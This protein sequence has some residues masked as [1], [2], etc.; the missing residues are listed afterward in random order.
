M[1]TSEIIKDTGD[2]G[3]GYIIRDGFVF[4]AITHPANIFDGVVI[5][6]PM[7]ATYWASRDYKINK[8]ISEQIEFVNLNRIEKAFIIAKDISFIKQCPT[9]KYLIICPADNAGD[10]FDFTPLYDLPEI[11]SLKCVT[12]Y[13][14]KQ[15][16]T[17][18]ID[19][20]K[21][22]G[23]E[24]L[25]IEGSGHLNYNHLVNLKSL[26]VS[27][28]KDIDLNNMISSE[29]LDTIKLNQCKVQSLRGIEK[30]CKLQCLYLE[31]NR[32]L[33]DISALRNVKNT[34]KLLRIENC[35]KIKDFS[36]LS[37]L[38]Q[39]ELLQVIGTTE[40][41][42][43]EFLKSL[44]NLKTFVCDMNVLDGNLTPCLDIPYVYISKYRKHYNLDP[45]NFTL[46][47]ISRGNEDIEVWRRME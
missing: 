24:S 7:N 34:I 35:A 11:K 2:L 41:E 4:R 5:M 40:I 20:S 38:H 32:A 26:S 28:S 30:S 8:S 29:I 31:Y 16:Y 18:N 13:G 37:E 10:N 46:N 45:K 6:D 42:S 36:V 23:L 43:L 14:R 47:F 9:L 15:E 12:R 27:G 3:R 21:I 33:S 25:S 44:P 22:K 1:R 39:L 19:Y 17:S